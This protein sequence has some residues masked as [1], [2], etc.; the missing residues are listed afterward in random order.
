MV[1]EETKEKCLN[2]ANVLIGTSPFW[3]LLLLWIW[4]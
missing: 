3:T 4:G 2:V 1:S